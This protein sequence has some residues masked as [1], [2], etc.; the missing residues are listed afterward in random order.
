[1]K[2]YIITDEQITEIINLLNAHSMLGAKNLL[3]QL[4]ELKEDKDGK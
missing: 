4:E 2:K 1:M 3:N